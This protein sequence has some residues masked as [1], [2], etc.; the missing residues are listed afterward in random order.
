MYYQRSRACGKGIFPSS[1]LRV[2]QQYTCISQWLR[3]RDIYCCMDWAE[4]SVL[5]NVT[6]LY[7]TVL[8]ATFVYNKMST[9][10]MPYAWRKGTSTNSTTLQVSVDILKKYYRLKA[11]CHRTFLSPHSQELESELE[12]C[13]WISA[14]TGSLTVHFRRWGNMGLCW[15]ESTIPAVLV[16]TCF[17][18]D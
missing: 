14:V 4:Y 11:F 18:D 7:V 10:I 12:R 2:Q 3:G 8:A 9:S 5:S 13:H 16:W 1:P 6:P 15:A 17:T